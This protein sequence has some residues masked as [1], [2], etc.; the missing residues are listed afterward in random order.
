MDQAQL[1]SGSAGVATINICIREY[2]NIK[3]G[4]ALSER[5][6]RDDYRELLNL[7]ALMA[8]FD[9]SNIKEACMQCIEHAVM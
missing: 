6:P 3:H 7:A 1:S 2:E 8:G 4:A 9:I 5:L